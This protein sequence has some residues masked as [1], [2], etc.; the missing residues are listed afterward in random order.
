MLRVNYNGAEHLMMLPEV[1]V[2]Q[3]LD[4]A[5]AYH[6]D[7]AQ[8]AMADRAPKVWAPP[9]QGRFQA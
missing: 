7:Q 9:G 4:E 1:P 8:K 6:Q 3:T 2:F 5:T